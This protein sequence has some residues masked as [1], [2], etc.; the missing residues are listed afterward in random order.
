MLLRWPSRWLDGAGGRQSCCGLC[1]HA[2][3]FW[4]SGELMPRQFGAYLVGEW[5]AGLLPQRFNDWGICAIQIRSGA[6]TLILLSGWQALGLDGGRGCGAVPPD[7]PVAG[8]RPV[9]GISVWLAWCSSVCGDL[10]SR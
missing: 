8:C 3:G 7:V 1:G 2:F 4:Q 10:R 6:D 5:L 9:P